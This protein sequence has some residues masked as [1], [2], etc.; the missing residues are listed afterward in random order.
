MQGQLPNLPQVSNDCK[1]VQ[2]CPQNKIA[3]LM[4]LGQLCDDNC[5]AI[6]NKHLTVV[7]KDWTPI[8]KAPRCPQTGMCLVNLNNP[9]SMSNAD[10]KHCSPKVKLQ[11][12][13]INNAGD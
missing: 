9:L 4:S 11:S 1:T 7:Y 6:M 8:I 5:M 3:T 12:K 13:R 10:I 2:M